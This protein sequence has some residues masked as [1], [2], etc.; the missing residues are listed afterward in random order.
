VI[1]ECTVSFDDTDPLTPS[2][3][4]NLVHFGWPLIALLLAGE[5]AIRK[6]ELAQK[7][8]FGHFVEAG[9]KYLAESPRNSRI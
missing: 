6:V 9:I 7:L 8:G 2:V 3:T 1:A 5:M 4:V